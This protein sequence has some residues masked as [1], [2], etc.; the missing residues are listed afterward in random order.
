MPSPRRDSFLCG[1][2]DAALPRKQAVRVFTA[3]HRSA[4]ENPGSAPGTNRTFLFD[5]AANASVYFS[6]SYVD[7]YCE[8]KFDDVSLMCR[9]RSATRTARS[10]AKAQLRRP[11]TQHRQPAGVHRAGPWRNLTGFQPGENGPRWA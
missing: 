9:T 8:K 5:E 1:I 3:G 10:A 2:F 6:G 7:L 4:D 11:A